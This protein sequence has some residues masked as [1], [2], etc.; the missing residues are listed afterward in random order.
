MIGALQPGIEHA[1]GFVI[2]IVTWPRWQ[3]HAR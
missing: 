2:A 3:F 1:L